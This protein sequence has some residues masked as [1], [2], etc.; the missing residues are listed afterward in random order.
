MYSFFTKI[1]FISRLMIV[2]SHPGPTTNRNSAILVVQV[3]NV[4]VIQEFM[5]VSFGT[6]VV[7]SY[8]LHRRSARPRSPTPSFWHRVA[9]PLSNVPWTREWACAKT[10]VW[11][12]VWTGAQTGVQTH[13]QTC[14]R[15]GVWTFGSTGA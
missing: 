8:G 9:R 14:A 5:C 10:F 6:E 12:G 7:Y 13:V 15:T 1:F 11:T 3:P 2:L 4:S